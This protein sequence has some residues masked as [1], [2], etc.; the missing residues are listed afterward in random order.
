MPVEIPKLN[1][2]ILNHCN[3]ML[4]R[5]K[6]QLAHDTMVSYNTLNIK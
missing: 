4:M 2:P 6:A 1:L 5:T 3:A